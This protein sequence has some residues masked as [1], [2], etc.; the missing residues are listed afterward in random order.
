MKQT[1]LPCLWM[2][3]GTS[4]G[5][6]FLEADLPTDPVVRNQVLLA[7][8]GSPDPRQIDGI[9]GGTPLTSKVAIVSPADPH[10]TDADVNYLFAQVV[11]DEARVD[12]GQNC[13]NILAGVGPFALERGLLTARDP[14]TPVRIRMRNTGQLAIAHVPTPCGN[15]VYH[16]DARIDGVPGTAA[17]QTIEFADVAGA[18]CGALLPTGRVQ[19]MFENIAVTCIDNGMPVVILR[20][21]AFGLTGKESPASLDANAALKAQ[22]EA[23]RQKAGKAMHL[24]DV[25]SRTVPKMCLVS[26]ALHGGAIHT[27]TFI[28]HHCH[29]A[30]G[31]FG[32][33]SVATACL[34]E[35][36]VAHALAHHG[37]GPQ[38]H[39]PI[40]HPGGEFTVAVHAQGST[41]VACGLLRTARALFDGQVLIPHAIWPGHP[42]EIA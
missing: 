20:A 31:V 24:G 11:V 39:L 26:P 33:V 12:F 16:G 3:G 19:D 29:E 21:D 32:A 41:I 23:I 35:G 10:D 28:P 5:A 17:G 34:L 37:P 30:I 4:K 7:A 9:G 18:T 2:R 38:H 13:G 1:R 22:L 8:L 40:E 27:R 14:I 36:S 42:P 6:Y 25:T 15:V